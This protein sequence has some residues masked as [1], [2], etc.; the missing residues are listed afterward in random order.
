M[1]E[2]FLKCETP[3]R[4]NAFGNAKVL[5]QRKIIITKIN[6]KSNVLK[7]IYIF[8]LIRIKNYYYLKAK[9]RVQL[10]YTGFAGAKG[11]F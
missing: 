11:A 3:R 1:G 4:L 5:A 9:S 10:V 8:V 6:K 2:V 7:I